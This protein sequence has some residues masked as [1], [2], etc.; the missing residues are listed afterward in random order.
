MS[1]KT[2]IRTIFAIYF[3]IVSFFVF[4]FLVLI[5]I[6]V[7]LKNGLYLEEISLP[8]LKV[9]QL[10]IKWNEKIDFSIEEIEI[11]YN[12]TSSE[13]LDYKKLEKNLNQVFL[14]SNIFQ[15]VTIEKIHY[16]DIDASFKYRINENGFIMASS[17]DFQL[18]AQIYLT[19]KYL[20]I[21]LEKLKDEKKKIFLDGDIFI[22]L[23]QH[24][25]NSKLSLDINHELKTLVY[26]DITQKKLSYK[27]ESLQNIK[28]LQY[29]IG[30]AHLPKEVKYW[31]LDAI[32][33][34]DLQI[35]SAYG[36]IEFDKTQEILKNIYISAKINKLNYTYNPKLD[37]IHTAFTLLEFKEGVLYIRPQKAYSY[38]QNLAKSWLKIDFTKKEELL[39]LQLLFDGIVDKSM[40]KI[41]R[42]Y[43]ITLP[44]VQNKG[45]VATDLVIK[46]GLR[47]IDI[48]A[49]G[50]FFVKKGNFHYLG[51]DVDINNA[52]VQLDNYDV[53]VDNMHA[54]YDNIAKTD[55]DIKYNAKSAAGTIIF[56]VKEV[57]TD[58]LSL[59]KTKKPLIATYY[60]QDGLDKIVVEK[61][62]WNTLE[63]SL[64]ID[65]LT[66][67]FNLN[68][69]SLALPTTYISLDGIASAYIAGDIDLKNMIFN[70]NTDL[71]SFEY[72]ELKL[73]Q[74]STQLKIHY[75]KKL[76]ISAKDE[77]IFNL[78]GTL[79][80]ASKLLV[81]VDGTTIDIKHTKINIGDFLSAN[82]SAKYDK[83]KKIELARVKNLKIKN[84]GSL[85]YKKSRLVLRFDN[86]EEYLLIASKEIDTVVKISKEQWSVKLNSLKNI[87]RG[88]QQ[89]K[90]L[91]L[92]E[93]NVTFTKNA[94]EAETRFQANINYPYKILLQNG[95]YLN[96][97]KI[98]GTIKKEDIDF[99]INNIVDISMG[100]DIR[101]NMKKLGINIDEVIKLSKNINEQAKSQESKNII[102]NATDSYLELGNGRKAIADTISLQYF[103]KILT[104]QLKHKKGVAGF[105]LNNNN[106]HL[107]GKDFNDEFMEKLF[108]LSKFKNGTLNF[109][110]SGTLDEYEGVFYIHNTTIVDYVILNNILAFINTIPSLTTFSIPGY[111]RK[112]LFVS[113]AYMKFKS[114]Q[115]KFDISDLFLESKEIEISGSGEADINKNIIDIDLVLKTDLGS[116]TAKI[117]VVG[118]IV[119]GKDNISTGVKVSGK[120]SDPKVKSLIVKDII[121]APLNIIKRTLLLPYNLLNFGDDKNASK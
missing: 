85:L 65:P 71:L 68:K 24:K 27:L 78:D 30:L 121:V 103:N 20:K 97:Y 120:L 35:N 73:D 1:D 53:R 47:N 98:I 90:R 11:H 74:S 119:L 40:L 18:E 31:A 33:M 79:L 13:G 32:D 117:P 114:L 48:D 37:A 57:K 108:T 92:T 50:N 59:R 16:N 112:G 46:V 17:K 58:A 36:H 116:T 6:A 88:S 43:N 9:K 39:T 56:R 52:N 87:S 72:S 101:I 94:N 5:F 115:G 113:E 23:A 34:K 75:D 55:V 84:N 100:D 42:T 111:N 15:S 3:S 109:S 67:A 12:D 62:Y 76:S 69:L 4:I 54:S 10:Y 107:Y 19:K 49:K 21:H 66:L 93:G 86:K 82:I 80:K 110:M 61:S 22:D 29:I 14:S 25:L 118:Y 95:K 7:I 89:L 104:A 77:M 64:T 2:I 26:L 106:F 99:N 28:S 105:K 81:E 45:K 102:L 96:T 41:L 63:K 8:N 51:L 83:K 70:F 91:N 60:I 44:F 38:G